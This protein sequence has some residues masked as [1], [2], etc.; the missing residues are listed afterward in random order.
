MTAFPGCHPANMT[1]PQVAKR[2]MTGIL[3][4]TRLGFDHLAGN[5][6]VVVVVSLR[7]EFKDFNERFFFSFDMVVIKW[8]SRLVTGKEVYFSL[9]V[10]RLRWCFGTPA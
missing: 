2:V 7:T 8:V 4:E 5:V 9:R 3:F 1:L 6:L 10:G